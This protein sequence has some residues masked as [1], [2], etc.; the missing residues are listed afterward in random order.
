MLGLD[1]ESGRKSSPESGLVFGQA[2]GVKSQ[3]GIGSWI[4]GWVGV[5]GR[6]RPYDLCFH[7]LTFGIQA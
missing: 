5:L 7:L 3:V 2:T 1:R 4:L 6:C